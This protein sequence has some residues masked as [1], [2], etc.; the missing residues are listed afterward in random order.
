MQVSVATGVQPGT[1]T[2]TVKGVAIGLTRTT[3]I[4]VVVPT[5]NAF[6][7]SVPSQRTLPQMTTAFIQVTVTRTNFTGPVT[8]SLENAPAGMTGFFGIN[9]VSGTSSLLNLTATANVPAGTYS[10]TIRGQSPG[11]VDQ[12]A[13]IQID[14]TLHFILTA[15]PG[16][17][18]RLYL[19]P[20]GTGTSTITLTRGNFV[21]DVQLSIQDAPSWVTATLSPTLLSGSATTSTLTVA[22][23]TTGLGFVLVRGQSG[24]VVSQVL[25][26][27]ES[28][29]SHFLRFP[30]VSPNVVTVAQGSSSAATFTVLRDNYTGPFSVVV[31]GAPAGMTVLVNPQ[32][33]PASTAVGYTSAALTINVSASVPPGIYTLTATTNATAVYSDTTTFQVEVKAPDGM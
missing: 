19:H 20:G 21:G 28:Q 23:S 7:L 18:D 5:A 32:P 2:I 29:W 10:L 12:T 1:Y 26:T 14:V 25:L 8:L 9:P 31:T 6:S 33:V 13:T 22:A 30:S 15:S 3:Q 11:Q 16:V 24:T 27:I 17:S 4:T